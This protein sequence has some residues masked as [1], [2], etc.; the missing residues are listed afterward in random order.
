MATI[1]DPLKDR[2]VDLLSFL[3]KPRKVRKCPTCE[4][5]FTHEPVYGRIQAHC[6][7][8]CRIFAEDV[9]QPEDAARTVC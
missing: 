7:S 8:I 1:L 3:T 4:G 2:S 5:Q 9:P 6:S